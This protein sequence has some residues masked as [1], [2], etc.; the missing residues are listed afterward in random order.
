MQMYFLI[1]FIEKINE[2]PYNEILS[3]ICGLYVGLI[4]LMYPKLFEMKK[5]ISEISYNLYKK[6]SSKF[7]I[8]HG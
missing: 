8:L 3:V 1:E 6:L 5:E 4:A 7:I 2:L